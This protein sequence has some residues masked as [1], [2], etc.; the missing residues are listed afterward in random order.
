MNKTFTVINFHGY[1]FGKKGN[2]S[3]IE[4]MENLLDRKGLTKKRKNILGGNFNFIENVDDR[5]NGGEETWNKE[6]SV[7][8]YFLGIRKEYDIQVS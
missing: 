7:R 5:K 1:G 2:R 3:K 6:K 4:L 8:E